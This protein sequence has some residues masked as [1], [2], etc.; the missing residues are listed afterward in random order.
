MQKP[1][2]P[3]DEVIRQ[4]DVDRLRLTTDPVETLFEQV[5]RLLKTVTNVPITAFSVLDHERQYF[6]SIQGLDVRETPRDISFCGHVILQDD[7]MVVENALEDERFSDNPLVTDDPSI[8]FY[9]GI[10]IRSPMGRKVGTICAIDR[11]ARKLSDEERAAMEDLRGVLET[12][13]VMRS[14]AITDTLTGLFNRRYFEQIIN[15]EWRRSMKERLPVA[16]VMYDLDDFRDYNDSLGMEAGD[17]VLRQV[18]EVLELQSRQQRHLV[19]R[20]GGEE[21]I[22][23][24]PA[25]TRAEAEGLANR[26]RQAV[27]ALAIPHPRSALGVVTVSA[28]IAMAEKSTQ[29]RRGYEAL[30]AEAETAL[31]EAKSGGCN[32][33][34]AAVDLY[35]ADHDEPRERSAAS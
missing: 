19:G 22:A 3:A 24:M 23:V 7:I 25:T 28:G 18:A 20:H 34:I 16:L 9:A 30:V 33:A 6:K 4:G 27:A 8:R 14:A 5:T 2:L 11:R 31:L 12:E 35:P 10:P 13:L 1:K 21:F 32:R 26:A 15:Y 29:L 17:A